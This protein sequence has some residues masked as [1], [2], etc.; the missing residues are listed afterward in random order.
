M[1][2][3]GEINGIGCLFSVLIGFLIIVFLGIGVFFGS[4]SPVKTSKKIVPQIEINI[5]N[6]KADT[7]Y[8]YKF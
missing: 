6:N 7:V 5:K 4:K 1:D 3:I 2:G 8:I